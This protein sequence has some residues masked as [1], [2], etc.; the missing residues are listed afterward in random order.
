MSAFHTELRP[1][2]SLSIFKGLFLVSTCIEASGVDLTAP[3]INLRAR[4][5]INIA[6]VAVI[7]A[8]EPYCRSG[9][10]YALY[11]AFNTDLELPH[12]LPASLF[13]TFFS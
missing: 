10:I 3:V 4:F 1:F 13:R 2:F 5:C 12:L 8:L 11:V 9:F 6:G 7:N